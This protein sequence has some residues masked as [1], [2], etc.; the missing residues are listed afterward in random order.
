MTVFKKGDRVKIYNQ[1]M[2]G[3]KFLEGIAVVGNKS[4]YGDTSYHVRFV[5]DGYQCERNLNEAE[6]VK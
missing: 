2:S 6:I 4:D 3:E 1:K 5:R